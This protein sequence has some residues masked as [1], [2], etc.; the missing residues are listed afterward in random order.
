M[1]SHQWL[2]NSQDLHKAWGNP[3]PRRSQ[4]RDCHYTHYLTNVTTYMYAPPLHSIAIPA[5]LMRGD[6][7]LLGDFGPE[8]FQ[9]GPELVGN[10][11]KHAPNTFGALPPKTD[12]NKTNSNETWNI[13]MSENRSWKKTSGHESPNMASTNNVLQQKSPPRAKLFG[14]GVIGPWAFL[15]YRILLSD[16]RIRIFS[17]AVVMWWWIQMG[18]TGPKRRWLWSEAGVAKGARFRNT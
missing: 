6:N 18:P 3:A 4:T 12:F 13:H 7:Y 16:Q 5:S 2:L 15:F 8:L 1:T 17:S 14:A 9:N 11:P 10:S